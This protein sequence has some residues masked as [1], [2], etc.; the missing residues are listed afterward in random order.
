MMISTT[1][2]VSRNEPRGSRRPSSEPAGRRTNRWQPGD[3][4]HGRGGGVRSGQQER[5]DR[6]SEHDPYAGA[7]REHAEERNALSYRPPRPEMISQQASGESASRVSVTG[8]ER[9]LRSGPGLRQVDSTQRC[10]GFGDQRWRHAQ[11]GDPKAD[12]QDRGR[13]VAG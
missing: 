13:R 9:R 4:E 6:G 7:G 1:A 2:V 5:H 8:L 11:L 3:E 12:E 10:L